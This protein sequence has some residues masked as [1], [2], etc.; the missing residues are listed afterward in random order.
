SIQTLTPGSP[1]P[2]D[3]TAASGAAP[4]SWEAARPASL[5]PFN[6]DASR[7]DEGP[8]GWMD[9]PPLSNVC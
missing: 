2:S 4:S 8:E 6:D 3:R 7:K 1:Q 9:L 5:F